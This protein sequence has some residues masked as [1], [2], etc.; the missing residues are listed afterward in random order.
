MAKCK[1]QKGVVAQTE[2]NY[3]GMIEFILADWKKK[4]TVK[5]ESTKELLDAM[6]YLLSNYRITCLI[7]TLIDVD[8]LAEKYYE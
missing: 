8:Q 1:K 4:G 7:S 6:F 2:K 5:E 3:E